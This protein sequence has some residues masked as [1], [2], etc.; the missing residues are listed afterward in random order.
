[1]R[2]S[3]W[4]TPTGGSDEPA[5]AGIPRAIE[6]ALAA[7]ALVVCSPVLAVIALGVWA[8]SPGPVVFRQ[9]RVGRDGRA[10]TLF[11]FR[12]MR[13]NADHHGVTAGGDPRVTPFGRWLRLLKLDELPELWNILRGEMSFVGARPEVPRLVDLRNPAWRATLRA[14]PGLTDP[15][16]LRLRNEEQLMASVTGDKERFYLEVLQP[17]KLAGY[18]EYMERRTAASDVRVIFRTLMAIVLP[19][20][21]P[22]PSIEEI[23]AS[24]DAPPPPRTPSAPETGR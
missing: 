21:A 18:V 2:F 11:K 23:R 14:R 5:A 13:V 7:L 8:S 12:T 10:F 9:V 24:V 19:S 15:V 3:M 4:S 22:T 16:T 6:A 20:S 1:M 17:F